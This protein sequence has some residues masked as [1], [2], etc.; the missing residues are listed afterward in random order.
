MNSDFTRHLERLFTISP[1]MRNTVSAHP[2]W[3]DWLRE[4]IPELSADRL[5][6]Y[7]REWRRF[8]GISTPGSRDFPDQLR[9]FKRR[10][11]LRIALADTAGYWAFGT[12]VHNLSQLA[13]AIIGA[14]LHHCWL[15]LAQDPTTPADVPDCPE[16]FA[17]L[18]M[19]KLGGNELNYSS[20]VDLL[21]FRRTSDS[22]E[23]L[24]FFT[25]LGERLVQALSQPGTDGF[26]YRVDMRLRPHGE[27]GPLVPTID[28]LAAYYE[29]WGEA[30]ERQALIKA[31][32]VAG[33]RD[34]GERIEDFLTRFTFSRQ[35]DDWSL[36]ELKRVKHRAEKEH[37]AG[38]GRVHIKQ[39][40]GGI[41][42][43]EFYTQYHQ[44]VAGNRY[45]EA[46][47]GS[48]LEALEGLAKSRTLLEGEDSQLSLAYLMLRTVEHRLQLRSLT[49]QSLLPASRGELQALAKGLGFGRPGEEAVPAFETALT[50]H[51]SRVRKILE[52]IYLTPG[53]LRLTEREEEFAQLLS[54]RTPRARARELLAAYGFED[55]DKA[56]QNLRLLA[57]G[58][59]G[60]H[61]PPNERRVFLE[62]V[63]P[64]LEVL[65]D[66]IDPD[67]ALHH[68]EGFAVASG[69][70][71]SFLRSLA[72]RRQHLARLTNLL[73]YSRLCHQILSRHPEFFDSLARGIHLHEGRTAAEMAGELHD[74]FGAAPK[75]ESRALI[76]RRYRQREMVRIAYRDMAGLAGPLEI[77]AELS[78]LAEA[79]VLTTLDI[80]RTLPEDVFQDAPEVLTCVSAGKLGS[81]QMHYA[82]DL[83]LV[84]FYQTS[85]APEIPAEKRAELQQSLDARVE[86]IIELL[87]DVTPE[88]FAYR[89]DL[90]LRPEGQS[91]L[92]A[93]SWDSFLGYAQQFMQPWERMAMVRSRVL[94]DSPEG[95]ARWSAILQEVVYDYVWDEKS[96]ESIRHLKRRAETELNR[97]SRTHIDFKHG[98]GGITELEYLVQ[99]LQLR[100][101][102]G[103]EA[104]RAQPIAMALP[105]LHEAGAI[106][107]DECG[108]LLEAHRFQRHVENHYQLQEE[109]PLREASRESPALTRLARS[110][111]YRGGTPGEDRRKFVSDWMQRAHEVRRLFE[112]YF[113]SQE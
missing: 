47:S 21:F 105:A 71:I 88:G 58:P 90:R 38:G 91:G 2:E 109:W 92:L 17:V 37:S 94:G 46:R 77:S 16:G 104:A 44:L 5:T 50:G 102:K 1:P 57:L 12:I 31:R 65:R 33:D 79:C 108:I 36:E 95:Q 29:S 49:P 78:D 48:T 64:L 100:Y 20:D 113:V 72:S 7:D 75:R 81:R 112:K 25:R 9:A 53:Y 97:E 68:L 55:A 35:L 85:E 111:G 98:K 18:A 62:F 76:L 70:R 93:R 89:V 96:L 61:L 67:L 101:G 15:L 80:S 73:A 30:W 66:S 39:G 87:K 45:P 6:D 40:P 24:R 54:E 14:A 82:S 3:L 34:L 27:A 107:E 86:S 8:P 84:F 52:R 69:N 28:S 41:R 42:D 103:N 23:E 19:G 99:F 51:R 63:F 10:E 13:D 22:P 110:M 43:I 56:W 59:A 83:D 32:F 26:L 11:Y 106:T 4:R 74:R 60:R